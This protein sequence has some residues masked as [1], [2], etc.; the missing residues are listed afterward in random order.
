MRRST[1]GAVEGP[2]NFQIARNSCRTGGPF[3]ISQAFSPRGG[4]CQPQEGKGRSHEQVHNGTTAGLSVHVLVPQVEDK[5]G[6]AVEKGK[7][8]DADVKLRRGCMVSPQVEVSGARLI[9]CAV[10]NFVRTLHQPEWVA[11]LRNDMMSFAKAHNVQN[12]AV[13]VT[14]SRSKGKYGEHPFQQTDERQGLLQRTQV[15]TEP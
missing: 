6:S 7:H 3:H 4:R 11:E 14:S 5:R 13:T 15:Q 1:W 9:N 10:R 12:G 8:S 2:A